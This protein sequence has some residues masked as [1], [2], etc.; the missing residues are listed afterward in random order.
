[1]EGEES[2]VLDNTENAGGLNWPL[3]VPAKFGKEKGFLEQKV[4]EVK[5]TLHHGADKFY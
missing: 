2:L 5:C 1:M 4:V 3:C